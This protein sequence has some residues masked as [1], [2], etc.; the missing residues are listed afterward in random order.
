MKL[1][2]GEITDKTENGMYSVALS[3]FYTFLII[4]MYD[5]LEIV[6]L[7]ENRNWKDGIGNYISIAELIIFSA[8]CILAFHRRNETSVEWLSPHLKR[9]WRM[10]FVSLLVA[11][12]ML[13]LIAL[14]DIGNN[15]D[16][17][18]IDY[19]TDREEFLNGLVICNAIFFVP[20]SIVSLLKIRDDRMARSKVA[21]SGSIEEDKEVTFSDI[22][23]S[24]WLVILLLFAMSFAFL[25][26]LKSG[27][28]GQIMS[29]FI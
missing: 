19:S 10:C 16:Y 29:W 28:I 21:Q 1:S 17:D 7:G 9:A 13:I 23:P 20:W 2:L 26:W 18:S 3:T 25:R 8:V 24:E 27:G 22:S 4:S 6:F 11:V 14:A 15:I 5:A 12:V